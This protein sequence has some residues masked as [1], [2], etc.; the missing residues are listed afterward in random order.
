MQPTEFLQNIKP[1]KAQAKSIGAVTTRK[2]NGRL[3]GQL[4]VDRLIDFNGLF[5]SGSSTDRYENNLSYKKHKELGGAYTRSEL[6]APIKNVLNIVNHDQ[7]PP[8][9]HHYSRSS[10][11]D[12]LYRSKIVPANNINLQGIIR[13]RLNQHFR[14]KENFNHVRLESLSG[15]TGKK[16]D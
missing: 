2:H 7:S 13:I 1:Y 9:G 15:I 5:E 14:R 11:I 3:Y 8:K 4:A 10:Y 12:D 16:C 6:R